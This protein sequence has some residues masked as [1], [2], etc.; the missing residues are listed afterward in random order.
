MHSQRFEYIYIYVCIFLFTF[1]VHVILVYMLDWSLDWIQ[2]LR[3]IHSTPKFVLAAQ[4]LW[5]LLVISILWDQRSL[6]PFYQDARQMQFVNHQQLGCSISTAC[7]QLL[8]T[9]CRNI[10]PSTKKTKNE[11]SADWTKWK[12]ES[13]VYRCLEKKS[14]GPPT[15]SN[16]WS[17]PKL[18][19]RLSCG[20][21]VRWCSCPWACQ[22]CHAEIACDQGLSWLIITN[23]WDLPRCVRLKDGNYMGIHV[24]LAVLVPRTHISWEPESLILATWPLRFPRAFENFNY[25]AHLGMDNFQ[26]GIIFRAFHY[27]CQGYK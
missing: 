7:C 24:V 1:T 12:T 8:N 20:F 27:R 3:Q 25:F 11:F 22:N 15:S 9:Q 2:T 13:A 16:I 18:P 21:L 6:V 10:E 23:V 5:E 14:H 19:P 26:S 17:F 4:N